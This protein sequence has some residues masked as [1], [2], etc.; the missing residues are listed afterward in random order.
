[1]SLA[2]D[3]R[4]EPDSVAPSPDT[5]IRIRF[6]GVSEDIN[7]GSITESRGCFGLDSELCEVPKC[8]SSI[9]QFVA[10]ACSN[11]CPLGRGCKWALVGEMLNA[12]GQ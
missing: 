6:D 2:H 10:A 9:T 8:G 7:A 4:N 3:T 11:V 12:V 1:V 5:I